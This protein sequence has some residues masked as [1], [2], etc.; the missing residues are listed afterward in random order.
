MKISERLRRWRASRGYGIH[1]PL[2]YRIVKYVVRPDSNVIYYGER[3][4]EDEALSKA[5]SQLTR[6]QVKRA[7]LLLRLVAEIEP[8]NVWVSPGMPQIYLDAIR[9][10][11]CV[12]RIYDGAVFPGEIKDADMVV[13]DGGRISQK[14]F[15]T[16]MQPGRTFVGFGLR[17]SFIRF[18]SVQV[19]GGILL[20]GDGSAIAVITDDGQLH[21]YEVS[22]F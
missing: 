1:S 17:E 2:A 22:R 12:V 20:E 7:R 4:L 21:Q 18:L 16:F 3:R 13:A 10:A 6:R 9:L 19:K 11:G 5:S 15:K 14:E 8:A